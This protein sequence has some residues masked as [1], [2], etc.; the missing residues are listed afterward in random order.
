MKLWNGSETL[1][2]CYSGLGS[3][4]PEQKGIL[5]LLLDD[6]DFG[7]KRKIAAPFEM[8]NSKIAFPLVYVKI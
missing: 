6:I 1:G 7:S 3:N 2:N 8:E 4:S 5:S